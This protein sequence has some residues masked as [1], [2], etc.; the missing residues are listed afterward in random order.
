VPSVN[1]I[2]HTLRIDV[3]GADGSGVHD[4]AALPRPQ[5]AVVAGGVEW[6]AGGTALV[7]MVSYPQLDGHGGC[8]FVDSGSNLYTM[9]PDGTGRRL[10]ALGSRGITGFDASAT[11]RR[12]AKL[13][14]RVGA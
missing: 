9:K 13:A 5:G 1:H 3:A 14:G 4:L 11:S 6:A 10:L 12:V 8:D 7:Y 2:R